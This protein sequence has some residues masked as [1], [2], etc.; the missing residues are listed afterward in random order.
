MIVTSA[1][2]PASGQGKRLGSR[3]DKAFVDICGIPLI[4][5]TLSVFQECNDITEIILVVRQNY[6]DKA[7]DLLKQYNITK[8]AKIVAGGNVRQDSVWNGLSAAAENCDI[9]VIHDAARPFI[10]SKIISA[11]IKSAAI[12]KAVIA[13][14]PVI[15]T[16]KISSDGT[17]IDS[18]PDRSNL[19]AVQTPQ[20]F[21]IDTIKTAY[22]S[23]YNDGYYGTDDASLAE[24]IGIKVKIIE[25]SY[26]NI[27]I[28]TP[29]DLLTAE[30]ILKNGNPEM[31]LKMKHRIGHGYD[32]HKFADGR[33]LVLG[34]VEF[35]G[36]T[37]LLG[38]SD[39]DVMLHAIADALLGA[40]GLGDIGKHFPDTD[41]A[42]KD[43]D[44]LI[45]LAHASTLVKNCGWQVENVDVTL[46]AERPK[47]AKASEQMKKNISE[48]I[49]IDPNG[50][51][52]K[53]STAE[54]LGDIGKGLGI[55]CYAVA[56]LT[57][58]TI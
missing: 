5:R 28:T 32:I 2:I 50:I 17:S 43:A 41:P 12:N 16:I 1:I 10:T 9:V 20:T 30:S 3:T 48:A 40:A 14:I 42:Y 25:G 51:N 26:N 57:N 21:A 19:F 33:R 6:I 35:P 53:A 55:E 46:V 47:I 49:G 15:D 13:A 23:A 38:H 11:S 27:K 44:S 56:I 18:T 58:N 22:K 37:G 4:I 39:A 34:G 31:E 29:N 8:P 54:G 36:D 45:L 24:R 52:I 7:S